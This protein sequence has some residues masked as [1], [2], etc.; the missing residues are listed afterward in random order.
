MSDLVLLNHLSGK[1]SRCTDPLICW[2]PSLLDLPDMSRDDAYAPPFFVH[3]KIIIHDI[4]NTKVNPELTQ[5]GQSAYSASES[6]KVNRLVRPFP[7][8]CRA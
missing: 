5:H 2:S 1:K 6:Y 4:W 7:E 3:T 8:S